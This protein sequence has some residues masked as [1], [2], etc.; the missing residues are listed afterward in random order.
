MTRR[1]FLA[2]GAALGGLMASSAL[3][4]LADDPSLFPGRGRFERLSLNYHHE[5]KA[6][7]SK[8][9]TGRHISDTH[10][11]AAYPDEG[12]WER[13]IAE[14][15]IRTFGGRQEEALRDS[16]AWAKLHTDYIVHTGDLIDFQSRANFDLVKK[17]YGEGGAAMLGCLGNHEHYRGKGER[18]AYPFPNDFS[19]TVL[20][21]VNFVMIDDSANTVSADQASRFEAEAKK[22]LPIVLCMHCPFP[23]REIVLAASRFW[24]SKGNLK[25]IRDM[26]GYVEKYKDGTTQDFVAYL[27]AQPL[28]K[29]ILC[30]H[31]HIGVVSPFSPTAKQ[32]EVAGNFMF[33]AQEFTVS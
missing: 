9:F 30:G 1:G 20:N 15:R 7:A 32:Y 2:G 8:P 5:I 13:K 10:L 23:T 21:G 14:R 31:G 22:G 28:L 17:Y 12:E 16:I 19:A 18:D 33:H 24:R 29:G 27:R 26:G 3:P 4:V 6:G 11:T 25:A